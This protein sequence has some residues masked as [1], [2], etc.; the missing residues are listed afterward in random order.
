[1]SA[2]SLRPNEWQEVV[3]S[4]DGASVC[5]GPDGT[6]LVTLPD[7]PL[8][9]GWSSK[10]TTVRFVVPVGYPAAQPDCFWADDDLRLADGSLPSNSG[11]QSA[12]VAGVPALWFSWHLSAW[13][14]A[15]DTLITY[16]R[17]ITRR[18]DDAR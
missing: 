7:V 14:P 17:F 12:P 16:V 18:F 10:S 8:P 4:F 11:A 13:R 3:G 15:L 5:E 9:G 2:L 6:T 1:L